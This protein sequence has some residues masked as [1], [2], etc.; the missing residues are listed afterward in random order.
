V[1]HEQ[2]H[3][4]QFLGNGKDSRPFFRFFAWP[5]S[6][7]LSL[8]SS[9]DRWAEE[10]V[11]RGFVAMQPEPLAGKRRGSPGEEAVACG[12]VALPA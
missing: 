5:A 12:F 1:P 9:E 8:A 4:R 11:G 3:A 2:G 6:L 10:A 7:N